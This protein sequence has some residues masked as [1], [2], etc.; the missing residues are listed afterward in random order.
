MDWTRRCQGRVKVKS[1]NTILGN[2][3][4]EIVIE[5]GIAY[6]MRHAVTTLSVWT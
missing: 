2:I 1:G 3:E 6:A 5:I 4:I